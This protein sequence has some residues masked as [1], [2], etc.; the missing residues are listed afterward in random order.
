MTGNKRIVKNKQ[1]RQRIQVNGIVQGVGFRPFVFNL[2]RSFS[3]RGFVTNTSEGVIIEV[4]GKQSDIDD[5]VNALQEQK[6]PL[7]EI[8]SLERQNVP[9]QKSQAFE[10][11]A[12]IDGQ[13]NQTLISPDIA[14]CDDCLREMRDP[15]DRRFQY[16]FI[17]CTNCGPRFTI[18][19]RIPYDRPNTSMSVFKMCPE[20]QTEY[21]DPTNR[22][23]HA[24]P[25]ACP[26]CGPHV[27]LERTDGSGIIAEKDK[28]IEQ[29][30]EQLLLGKIVA[31]KGLGG[32]HLAVDATKQTAVQSLR[33]RKNREQKPLA[34]MAS[35]L[36]AV[37]KIVH[38]TEAEKELLQSPQRPIVL[39]KKK[40]K[41]V[42]AESVAPNNQRLGIMLPYTPLHYL[43]FDKLNERLAGKKA[44]YLV[45]TSAN[46]S[47]EPIVIDND[48]ARQRLSDI[49]DYLLLHNRDILIR[50][51]DSVVARF[52]GQ[53][54]FFRRSRGYVPRPV[55]LSTKIKESVLGVGGELKNTICL[56]KGNRAFLSQH[57]GDLENLLANQFFE[58]T[59]EHFKDILQT[60][61]ELIV[62]DMHPGYFSTQWAVNQK[63]VP[64]IEVQHHHAHMAACMAEWQ[65][66]EPVIGVILDGT[67]YGYDGTVWGGEIFIGDFIHLERM[68]CFKPLRI[69]GGE[70][71][72]KQ[73]WR[74]ALSYLLEALHGELPLL[75]FLKHKPIRLI[76]Q[77]LAKQLNCPLTSSCGR[78]FDGASVISGGRN[79]VYYEAQAAIEF[80]QAVKNLNVA[81]LQFAI[82]LPYIPFEPI[83][84]AL[85]ELALNGASYAEMAARFHL[86][87]AHLLKAVVLKIVEKTNIKKIVL[88]GGVFQNEVLL[89][90]LVKFLKQQEL[91]VFT[92]RQV[93]PNDGGIALGQ[94][95][96]GL[97]LLESGRDTVRFVDHV[98]S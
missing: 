93:P 7:A 21:E 27:W 85:V 45:M 68:A 58:A 61:P 71:A 60:S 94:C 79:E 46:R 39:L 14:I 37:E 40:T 25:N 13:D 12:S 74:M 23:F 3:L 82:D 54:T 38:L 70:I 10:I 6:P 91:K 49:A 2:A 42:V 95:A 55:F 73:P 57:I 66:D 32:F 33:R 24:Q 20:C 17:N 28:A 92:H 86:T 76:Q 84:R 48:E 19:K 41:I 97:R 16:P 15:E 65:I 98:H 77:Q 44:V 83:I 52:N 50:A 80:T 31:I 89:H 53:T 26:V 22:R 11:I 69:P 43:I 5:F 96:I 72:I 36:E 1:I 29:V 4:Q 88:S 9:L 75:P 30:V 87:M 51:D 62:R 81:P 35:D 47:E 90:L 34:I 63:E 56:T 64:V 59:I 78:L 67:G 18:I 8:I